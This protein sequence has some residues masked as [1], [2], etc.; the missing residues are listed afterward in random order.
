MK[1][2]A[3]T[4]LPR[5][6]LM[7][8]GLALFAIC[9]FAYWKLGVTWWL[10]AALILAPDLAMVGYLAGPRFGAHLY[11]A[12]HITVMPLVLGFAGFFVGSVVAMAAAAVWL[13]HIGMDRMLGFGL[14]Y[15]TAF[16]DTHLGRVGKSG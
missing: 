3:V 6:L 1:A 10:F 8:E 13:A 14:K 5:L 12:A 9:V 4:G 16:G 15:E 11:N 7:A 2:S